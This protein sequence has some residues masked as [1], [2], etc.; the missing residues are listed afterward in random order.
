MPLL[1]NPRVKAYGFKDGLL[2]GF[3]AFAG[4]FYWCLQMLFG[5]KF[6]IMT[7]LFWL[8]SVL[9]YAFF[10]GIWF[11]VQS[12]LQKLLLKKKFSDD[13]S[14]IISWLVSGVI[15]FYFIAYGSLFFGGV[16]PFT[17]PFFICA[18]FADFTITIDTDPY[19]STGGNYTDMQTNHAGVVL[20]NTANRS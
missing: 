5:Y 14:F 11:W 1:I 10:S 4:L 6:N 20:L 7:V 16:Y 8:L 12:F 15:F 3:I 9:Y 19:G 17:N 2:W 18:Q 13:M